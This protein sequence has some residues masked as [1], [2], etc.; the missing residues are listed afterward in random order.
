MIRPKKG[1]CH[2]PKPGAFDVKED[3]EAYT[4]CEVEN[5]DTKYCPVPMN[6]LSSTE[7]Y[8]EDTLVLFYPIDVERYQREFVPEHLKINA[9]PA[10]AGNP[11]QVSVTG[12]RKKIYELTDRRPEWSRCS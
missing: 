3:Q 6:T 1:A 2:L 11:N 7:I 5:T 4:G 12:P 8:I 9:I 10:I